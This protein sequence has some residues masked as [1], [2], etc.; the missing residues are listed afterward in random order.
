[1]DS[2]ANPMIKE[3]PAEARKRQRALKK[4]RIDGKYE[5][6]ALERAKNELRSMDDPSIES[7]MINEAY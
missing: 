1:M 4:Q 5:P 2:N 3:T 7:L 6:T